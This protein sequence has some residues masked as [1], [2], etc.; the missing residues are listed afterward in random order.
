V[1]HDRRS[2]LIHCEI[3]RC[4]DG[5]KQASSDTAYDLQ[6]SEVHSSASIG[7]ITS[8]QCQ[9]NAEDVVRNADVAMYEAKRA[10][11]LVQSSDAGRLASRCSKSPRPRR[12]RGGLSF[13]C[14]GRHA[15]SRFQSHCTF[16]EA[17][18]YA[19]QRDDTDRLSRLA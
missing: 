15:L 19:R 14:T 13:P 4:R 10:G 12:A 17:P 5:C 3:Y 11:L 9:T 1:I 6:G 7:I 2:F 16:T 8:D 18:R